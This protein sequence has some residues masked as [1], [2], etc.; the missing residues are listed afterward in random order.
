[1][2]KK[3]I[4]TKRLL[5]ANKP[6]ERD[7]DI[8]AKPTGYRWKTSHLKKKKDGTEGKL[9][10]KLH[11]KRPTVDE[12]EKYKKHPDGTYSD[13]KKQIYHER[14]KDRKHSDDNIKKKFDDGGNVEIVEVSV[15]EMT[16]MLGR[17]PKYP[18]DF[19]N[20]KKYVKCFLRP[21]YKCVD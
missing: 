18:C 20:G 15:E 12:I 5:K 10:R 7:K 2:A 6:S 11:F 13:D 3:K 16:N 14:R 1:M 9:A 4:V 8:K 21:Y 17:E 19:I